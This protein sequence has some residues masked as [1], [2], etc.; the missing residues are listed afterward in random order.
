MSPTAC[1]PKQSLNNIPR[2]VALRLARICD[3][4]EKLNSRSIEYKNYFI[5]RDFK[6]FIVNKLFAHDST[7]SRQQAR[8]KSTNRKSDVSQNVELIKKYNPRLPDLDTLLKKHMPLRYTDA[9]LKAIS[10]KG[11]INSVFKRYQS[12][13]EILAPCLY[14][15]NKVNKPNFMTSCNKCDIYKNYLISSNYLTCNVPNRRYYRRRV[16]HCD[17]NNVIYLI[18]C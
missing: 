2:G 9:A 13:K 11:C 3:T 6:P 5:A 8:Q 12:L 18:T 7:L 16:L 1:Y 4:D 17:Y 14:P 15:N 10:P